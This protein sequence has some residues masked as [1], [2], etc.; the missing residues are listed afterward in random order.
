MSQR[1]SKR[2]ILGF[3]REEDVKEAVSKAVDKIELERQ[4]DEKEREALSLG[5]KR[6]GLKM[7]QIADSYNTMAK[8]LCALNQEMVLEVEK[9]KISNRIE[10]E[11]IQILDYLENCSPNQIP[12]LMS[13]IQLMNLCSLYSSPSSCKSMQKYLKQISS[14][15]VRG[16]YITTDDQII[17]DLQIKIPKMTDLK[18]D[19]IDIIP[20]EHEEKFYK[21]ETFAYR[22]IL[23]DNFSSFATEDCFD[24]E[25]IVFCPPSTNFEKDINCCLAGIRWNETLADCKFKEIESENQCYFQKIDQ[26][27]VIFSHVNELSI[28][29]RHIND[30]AARNTIRNRI[31]LKPGVNFI[32][33]SNIT[34]SSTICGSILVETGNV[35]IHVM[36]F[37][38]QK[39]FQRSHQS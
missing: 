25:E 11:F 13:S 29:K 14:C 35:S 9:L 27:G 22:Y 38:G 32:E 16:K 6:N 34:I 23:Y 37:R 30:H 36:I 8:D 7:E 20:V 33:N 2:A 18:V 12:A 15:S 5:I 3:E 26:H 17:I 21:L 28:E 1:I 39:D 31:K 10:D 24:Y 19:E 4:L